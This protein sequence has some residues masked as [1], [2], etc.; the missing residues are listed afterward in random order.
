[1]IPPAEFPRHRVPSADHVFCPS[2]QPRRGAASSSG[3]TCPIDGVTRPSPEGPAPKPLT[4][5]HFEHFR[6]WH[7]GVGGGHQCAGGMELVIVFCF[8]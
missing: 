3:L 5:V 7:G 2:Q 4:H 6:V 1:V 8:N